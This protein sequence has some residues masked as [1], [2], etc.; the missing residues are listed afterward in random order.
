MLIW[1][2]LCDGKNPFSFLLGITSL[3]EMEKTKR[4]DYF[5]DIALGSLQTVLQD[6][7]VSKTA[8]VLGAI[9]NA[10]QTLPENRVLKTVMSCLQTAAHSSIES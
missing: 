9:E 4:D 7:P 1:R 10:L 5:V 8:E 2:I 3:E 6:V